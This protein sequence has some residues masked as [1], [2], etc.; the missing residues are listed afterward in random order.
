MKYQS[1]T[2]RLANP[3]LT[4]S[5][6]QQNQQP[7]QGKTFDLTAEFFIFKWVVIFAL[8]FFGFRA[9]NKLV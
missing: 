9:L 3:A 2:S 1:M 4:D 5:L 6:Y 7:Q 8:L